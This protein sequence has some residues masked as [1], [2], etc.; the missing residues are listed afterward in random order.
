MEKPPDME[1]GCECTK[2]AA[3]D[4]RQWMI[5][6]LGGLNIGLITTHPGGPW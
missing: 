2:H 3:V 6:Q 5:L 4:S 1:D